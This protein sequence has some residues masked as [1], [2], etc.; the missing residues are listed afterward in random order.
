MLSARV[1]PPV[2]PSN[3]NPP[4]RVNLENAVKPV[5][6]L[7]KLFKKVP[8]D[9]PPEYVHDVRTQAR[10]LEASVHAIASTRDRRA[11]RLLK[12]V[13]PVRK[14]AGNVRDMDVMIEKVL[15]ATHSMQEDGDALLRLTEE[16]SALREKSATELRRLLKRHGDPLRDKL[17]RYAARAKKGGK[18]AESAAAPQVLAAQLQHWPPLK[19][20]NLHEFRIHAKELRYMLQLTPETDEHTLQSF[21]HVKDVAGEW[22]DWLQLREFAAKTLDQK[23]DHEILSRLAA[24]EHQKLRAALA[25]ANAARRDG[26]A[27]V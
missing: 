16:M 14:A 23:E 9:L 27:G 12:Q 7:R 1:Q 21:A 15:A 11:R 10:K 22:H 2:D 19:P 3:S 26:M 6:R 25:A 5:R 18:M 17:K 20:E 13:K 8:S 4:M 24:I